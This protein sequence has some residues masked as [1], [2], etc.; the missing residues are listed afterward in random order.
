MFQY[1]YACFKAPVATIYD[2]SRK[3]CPTKEMALNTK[4][5]AFYGRINQI[6]SEYSKLIKNICLVRAVKVVC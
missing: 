2:N 1:I 4:I 6:N 3:T 5:F